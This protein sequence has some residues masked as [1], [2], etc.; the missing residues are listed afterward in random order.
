MNIDVYFTRL[1][2]KNNIY[3]LLHLW[4]MHML[5]SKKN[6][7]IPQRAPHRR[8]YSLAFG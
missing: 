3:Y 6:A 7:N 4:L 2:G 8:P 1:L 5:W